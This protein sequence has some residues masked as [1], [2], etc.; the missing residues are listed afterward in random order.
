MV[1]S[2]SF[3]SDAHT[4]PMSEINTTP[5]RGCDVGIACDIHHHC[6]FTHTRGKN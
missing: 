2:H 1:G 5:L 3:N 6:P 4:Q